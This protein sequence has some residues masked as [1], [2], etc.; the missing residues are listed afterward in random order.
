MDKEIQQALDAVEAAY[1]RL[2]I[3]QETYGPNPK[4][5]RKLRKIRD[6]LRSMS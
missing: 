3:D 4:R 1:Q 5:E 2:L 6:I